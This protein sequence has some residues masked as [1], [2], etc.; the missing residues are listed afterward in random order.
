MT[1]WER[2][3]MS[4]PDRPRI[5]S[6]KHVGSAQIQGVRSGGPYPPDCFYQD[7]RAVRDRYTNLYA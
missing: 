1:S 2:A 6:Y 5:E 3:V 7:P 4:T